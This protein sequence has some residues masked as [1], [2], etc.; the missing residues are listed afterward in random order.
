[1]IHLADAGNVE[2]AAFDA[3]AAADAVLANE[4]DDAVGVL[5]DGAGGRAGLE[6]TRILAMHAAILANQ[7]LQIALLVLIFGEAHQ[8]PGAGVQIAGIV[9]GSLEMTDIGAQIIPLHAGGLARLAADAAAHIDQLCYFRLMIADG[10]W[11]H[12]RCRPPNIVLRL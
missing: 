7:P 6:A 2:R 4:I 5:H 11:R 12:R 10:G 9:V 8:G 1:M 3:V